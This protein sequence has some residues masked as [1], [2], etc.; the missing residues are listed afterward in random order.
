MVSDDAMGVQSEYQNKAIGVCI[1]PFMVIA[2]LL[3]LSNLEFILLEEN[4]TIQ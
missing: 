2:D 1:P 4:S 3:S